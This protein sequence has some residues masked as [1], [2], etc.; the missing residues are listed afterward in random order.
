MWAAG[1]LLVVPSSIW[2]NG[3]ILSQE[4]LDEQVQTKERALRTTKRKLE[5]Q[6][7]YVSSIC[8]V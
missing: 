5:Q 3:S 4:E 2:T 7:E 1:L 8:R 6:Q